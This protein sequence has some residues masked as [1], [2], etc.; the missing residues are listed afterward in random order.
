[1]LIKHDVNINQKNRLGLTGFEIACQNNDLK[2]VKLLI[3]KSRKF[4]HFDV[5]KQAAFLIAS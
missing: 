1:M 3:E 5:K 2:T 4:R